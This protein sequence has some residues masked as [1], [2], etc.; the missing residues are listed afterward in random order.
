MDYTL[1]ENDIYMVG[2]AE[3]RER[4]LADH[5]IAS[6]NDLY[7]TS[8]PQIITKVFRVSMR[9]DN[10][11]RTTEEEN[12]I[13]HVLV[14][15]TFDNVVIEKP[16]IA[17][18]KTKREE[19]MFPIMALRKDC[20]YKAPLFVDMNIKAT[21][22][23]MDGSTETREDNSIRHFKLCHM[24]IMVG[25]KW[26]NRH[27]LSREALENLHEDPSDPGG[28]FIIRGV[29][30]V[31]DCV[32]N[33]LF[34]EERIFRNEGYK[35][36][37][38]RCEFISKPGDGNLNSDQLVI[39]WNNDGQLTVEIWQ[40]KLKEI[41]FPFFLIFR[42]LGWTTDRQIFDNI[43]LEYDSATSAKIATF[44]EKAMTM[45]YPR[46]ANASSLFTQNDVLQYVAEQIKEPAFAHLDVDNNP[47]N[48]QKIT[49]Y[50]LDT[51][52]THFLQHLGTTPDSRDNKLRF[53]C[54][55]IHKIFLVFLGKIAPTDRDSY[56][57]KRVHAAGVLYT[58]LF[59]TYF[60]ASII[61]QVRR[62]M[63][64]DFKSMSFY[65][66]NL[67]NSIRNGG[68]DVSAFDKYI[69]QAI[70]AGSKS[71]IMVNRQ[72]RINRLSSQLHN[73]KNY[74]G[75][76]SVLRQVTASSTSNAKQSDREKQLRQVH[77]SF[78]GYI[79]V[80]HSPEGSNVGKN[81]QFTLF[82]HL[83]RASSSE[84]VKDMLRGD[85][86]VI[87]LEKTTFRD[88]SGQKLHSVYVNGDLIGYCGSSIA[89]ANKYR[90][91]RRELKL[92]PETTIVW[93]SIENKVR[94][95]TDVGRVMRPLLI[96]YNNERDPEHVA[97]L[98]GRAPLAHNEPFI[99]GIALTKKHIEGLYAG[100]IGTADLLR[101]G[102]IEYISADEQ[103][104]TYICPSYDTLREEKH[105]DLK[106][107]TH[108]DIAQAISGITAVTSPYADHNQ[109]QRTMF[110][111][112]QCKQAC[113]HYAE[114]GPY[115]PDKDVFLQYHV[116]EPMVKTVANRYLPPNGLN[117]IVAIACYTGFNVEDSFIFNKGAIDRGAFN[118]YK[119]T[120]YKTELEQHEEFANP[121]ASNTENIQSANFG[122]LRGGI[123]V[124]GT[125]LH[126]DDAVIGKI[127]KISKKTDDTIQYVDRSIIYKSN[128]SAVVHDVIVDT[129]EDGDTFCKVILRKPR[130]VGIGDKFAARSGQK[131]TVGLFLDEA[132]MPMTADGMRPT[133]IMNPHGIPSRMTIGQ[134]IESFMGGLCAEKATQTDG[135]MFKK[136]DIESAQAE[137]EA[138]GLSNN[139]THR[140]Y[141]G[142]TGQYIDCMVFAGPTFF[143]RIQ[144][145]TADQ[146][147]SIARGSTDCLTH[148]PLDGM[149]AN[150][151]LKMGEME[152]DVLVAHGA[153]RLLAEKWFNHSDGYTEYVCRCGKAAIVN[154]HAGHYK[155]KHCGDN[156]DFV[157]YP[158]SWS[159]KLFVQELESMNIGIRRQPEP[160]T[161]DVHDMGGGM[162]I[163]DHGP[164]E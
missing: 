22:V 75:K 34:N 155:C 119:G 4:G 60:N 82:A 92:S 1:E 46:F 104:N 142:I 100:R 83:T 16:T 160:H 161:Y 131:G 18:L 3:I 53:L 115:R 86:D 97:A 65:H 157:A 49:N 58:K 78:L 24:P 122:H 48:Y 136:I 10:I 80:T 57:G 62:K 51:M 88:I 44:L 95:W 84:V 123:P 98:S 121:D 90:K 120:F 113:G 124:V 162:R 128:E 133:I 41:Q 111:C 32:E 73:Q 39:R 148:Q 5:H 77:M 71:E 109:V 93:K 36:E 38:M 138:L 79:C 108:C 20:T 103:E 81:K 72:K 25:T 163:E 143:E 47:E 89:L 61:Q 141:S 45:R 91:L 55:L 12:R 6:G 126:K 85:P 149:S 151:G 147:Y 33:I 134:L 94:F 164:I 29:E 30:W 118:G 8:I 9:L 114:N 146:Q 28:Y 70:S 153:M 13:R 66:I 99:Q 56:N 27:G 135:T 68:I 42:M 40:D 137:L 76:I 31:I 140:F 117:V 158:T 127:M 125:V 156:G 7:S 19:L 130:P 107:Y 67:S 37:V 116:E 54:T 139:G 15:I 154:S 17:N 106:E 59:K 43:L 102:V 105:N 26:C 23:M 50:I 132:D 145:F 35:K 63:I 52:D 87:P 152:R 150:G 129:N 112:S 159:A 144:K 96:V 11:R 64:S 14:D 2:D 74:M 21:A 110:R 101:D 69:T